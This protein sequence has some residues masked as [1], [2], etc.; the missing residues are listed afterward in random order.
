MSDNFWKKASYLFGWLPLAALFASLILTANIEIKDLDFWLHLAMGK[1]IMLHRYVPDVDV[2]SCSIQGAPW[3]NHEWLFQVV[4]Y[5]IYNVWG[6]KGVI[7]MQVVLVS[8]TMLLLFFI[9]NNKD[10][11]FVTTIVLFFVFMVYQ[12]RFTIRPDLYSLLFFTIYIFVLSL[13]IDKKW[14]VP[15]LMVVQVLWSNMHGF[16]FFGPLFVLIGIVSEWIKRNVYLPWEWGESGRLTDD[17]YSRMKKIFFFVLLSCLMNPAFVKG[18]LYPIGVFFSLSGENKI[19]FD[20]IQELQRPI[21]RASL[22]LQDKYLYYKILI[23]ISTISFIFNRRRIDVSA[24]LFWI[25]FLVFS[26]KATRNTP[27]FACAAYLVFVTNLLHIKF[28]NIFPFKFTYKKFQYLT[29]IILNL[30]LFLWLVGYYQ[31]ITGRS[32]YD[33]DKY[34]FKSEYGDVSQKSYPDKAA[35]FLVKHNIKGNFFNDFNSG[36]YLLGR[37]FPDI[38]VFIDGRTEVYGG[39]FFEEYQKM[40]NNGDKELLDKVIQQHNLSGALLNA[41]RH[42]VPKEILGYFYNHP[43]WRLVYF[44][45]DALIFLRNIEANK[46]II[47]QFEIDLKQWQSPPLDLFKIG[48]LRVKPYRPYFRAYTLESL[49]LNDAALDELNAVIGAAPLYAEAHN[50]MGKVYTKKGNY[51]KG[52]EHFRIAATGSPSDKEVRHNLALACYDLGEDECA[53][54]QY[55]KIIKAWPGDPKGYFLLAKTYIEAGRYPEY[56]D[57]VKQAHQLRPGNEKDL[58]G[59]GDMLVERNAL[60]EAKATYNMALRTEKDL[61]TIHRKIG[62]VFLSMNEHGQAKE[63]LEKALSI[64]PDNQDINALLQGL[65]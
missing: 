43:D 65:K 18:A 63:E 55:K 46:D 40:W 33:W 26:L 64:T 8:M 49:D 42:H 2:L 27:F 7:T 24:L 44:D 50:L 57:I 60:V 12:Q 52:F 31:A 16:F 59:L 35:D 34:E 56:M 22:F 37:V 9:G 29:I 23:V 19:F 21:T 58:I 41:T 1:F 53:I 47:D 4:L 36:A 28:E 14:S 5:N 51:Q 15:V 39:E 61:A 6:A 38:K 17:E 32:Y 20:Y 48:A 11:Q 54:T 45:Y 62:E 10:K 30:M 13:H 25:V 3:V